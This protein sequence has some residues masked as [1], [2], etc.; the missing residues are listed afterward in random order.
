MWPED[1]YPLLGHAAMIAFRI[2]ALHYGKLG[3]APTYSSAHFAYFEIHG[4]GSGNSDSSN[5]SRM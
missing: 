2:F 5:L 4:R 3:F 1:Q